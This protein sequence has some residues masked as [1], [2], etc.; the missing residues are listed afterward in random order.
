MIPSQDA[1]PED[2]VF[3]STPSFNYTHQDYRRF[4]NDI[5]FEDG[6]HMWE[7]TRNLTA[8]LPAPGVQVHCFYGVGLPTPVTYI[9]DEKF[10]NSDP[11]NFLYKDGDDTVDSHSMSL[12]KRWIGKQQQPVHVTEFNG[13]A[14]LDIVFNHNVLSAIQEI[15]QGTVQ[16]DEAVRTIFVKQ[17]QRRTLI[18]QSP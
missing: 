18:N 11:V 12:C 13:M 9:Y 8:D 6:W 16:K 14:H 1:W 4:F 10:P 15:L 2:H 17:S 3:I 5:N 7:D